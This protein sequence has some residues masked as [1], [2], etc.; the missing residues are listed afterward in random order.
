MTRRWQLHL[1]PWQS[2]SGRGVSEWGWGGE[3]ERETA[4]KE[5][6]W[7][8]S[9]PG[10]PP[11]RP[12]EQPTVLLTHGNVEP[13]CQVYSPLN[14]SELT[15][16]AKLKKTLT[17]NKNNYSYYHAFCFLYCLNVDLVQ[18]FQTIFQGPIYWYNF[19]DTQMSRL[20]KHCSVLFFFSF[21]E[22]SNLKPLI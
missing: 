2:G 1:V 5:E 8:T 7:L 16:T 4:V 10:P 19:F 6:C 3:R 15:E 12:W 9:Y 17:E 11:M 18:C 20:V 21:F 14:T 22:L 13:V